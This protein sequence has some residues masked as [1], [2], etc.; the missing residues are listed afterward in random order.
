[1]AGGGSEASLM[2]RLGVGERVFCGIVP[3]GL[4]LA[5]SKNPSTGVILQGCQAACRLPDDTIPPI[6]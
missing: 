1:M 3:F 2:G 4:R 5:D 6:E